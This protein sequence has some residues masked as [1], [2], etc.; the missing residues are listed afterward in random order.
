MW[1]SGNLVMVCYCQ[2]KGTGD[3]WPNLNGEFFE[4]SITFSGVRNLK[5]EL[6]GPGLHPMSGF[7][8]IDVSDI[9]L[10]GI[11]FE[12]EDYEGGSIEFCCEGIVVNDVSKPALLAI[13]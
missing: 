2:A 5:L 7:D 3:E 8:I 10:E 6:H 11:N 13:D 12:V 4:V 9:G 1:V